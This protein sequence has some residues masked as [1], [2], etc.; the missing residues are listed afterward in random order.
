MILVVEF[1]FKIKSIKAKTNSHI[2]NLKRQNDDN[3]LGESKQN[4]E[5]RVGKSID[6]R[7]ENQLTK[8]MNFHHPSS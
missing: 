8:F 3:Q 6:F 4:G 7:S 2:E 1:E 5:K